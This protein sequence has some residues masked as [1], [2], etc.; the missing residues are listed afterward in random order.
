[1]KNCFISIIVVSLFFQVDL[2]DKQLC[3]R[4]QRLKY[5]SQ[6][7]KFH[8]EKKPVYGQDLCDAVNIFKDPFSSKVYK[9]RDL[10]KWH[11]LGHIHCHCAKL[12]HNPTHPKY[13]WNQTSVLSDIIHTPEQY[14]KELEDIVERFVY[15][16]IL[17]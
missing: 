12:C 8:C 11:G 9:R 10:S 17:I 3:A 16:M 14:L 6:T 4:Q 1:M 5:I 7:N 15:N 2:F 13:V